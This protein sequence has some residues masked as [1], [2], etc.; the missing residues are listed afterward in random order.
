M[1]RARRKELGAIAVVGAVVLL[2]V[3]AFMALALNVGML[4]KTRG[5][6]QNGSDSAALAAAGSINGTD[7]GQQTARHMADSYAG[8]HSVAEGPVSIDWQGNDVKFG[9]WDFD[10]RTFVES[11]DNLLINAVKVADGT[12]GGYLRNRPLD[13]FFGFWLGASQ[14]SVRSSA[15]AVG[16]GARTDC[17]MPF[18]LPGCL[19][20]G[21]G[22]DMQCG[23]DVT[24]QFSNDPSDTVGFIFLD[25]D[26]HGHA[27]VIEEI[28]NRCAT[29][30][31]TTGTYNLQNGEDIN[32]GVAQAL[33]GVDLHG[34]TVNVV[35]KLPADDPH[36]FGETSGLCVFNP[37]QDKNSFPLGDM[38]CPPKFSGEV[39]VAQFARV[40]FNW[41]MDN[42]GNFYSSCPKDGTDWRDASST[43]PADIDPPPAKG[44]MSVRLI[45][46]GGA[47]L[48]YNTGVK[49][50][51][52]E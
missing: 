30:I 32:D 16:R 46:G 37:N 26:H 25:P 18:V 52:V 4:M 50:R 41:F 5:E 6:L 9:R 19:F 23:T 27:D 1:R 22:G 13:V 39:G 40:Q 20:Q 29:P 3:G 31:A 12:D 34:Q 21:A 2:G 28:T 35:D 44:Q 45:C 10:T 38:S 49:L 11:A 51:L 7:D 8:A 33:L 43:P 14:A 42:S 17:P 47:G 48:S 36:G 24:L 15:V